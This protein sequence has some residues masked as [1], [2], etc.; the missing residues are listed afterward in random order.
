[1]WKRESRFGRFCVVGMLLV[2]LWWYAILFSARAAHAE[3]YAQMPPCCVSVVPQPPRMQDPPNKPAWL[4]EESKR[5]ENWRAAI[6]T[7]PVAQIPLG[8]FKALI[9]RV[10][11]MQQREKL[12]IEK[13]KL[14]AE[15]DRVQTDYIAKIEVANDTIQAYANK[16]EEHNAKMEQLASEKQLSTLAEGAGYGATAAAVIGVVARKLILKF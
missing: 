14:S 2:G 7:G 11:K 8:E 12:Y 9:N 16:L 3:P 15:K 6:Q 1:M 5:M 4:E 10:D 13:D